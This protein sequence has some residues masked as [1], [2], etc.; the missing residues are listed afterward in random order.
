MSVALDGDRTELGRGCDYAVAVA[1][2][3]TRLSV[4]LGLNW[5]D[6]VAGTELRFRCGW[7]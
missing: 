5:A 6:N 7:E 3:L 2:A 1:G 4:G